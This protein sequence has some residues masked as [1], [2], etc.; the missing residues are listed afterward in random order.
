MQE[1]VISNYKT[2]QYKDVNL[3]K[4]FEPEGHREQEFEFSNSVV[5]SPFTANGGKLFVNFYT[6]LPG[7]SSYPYH[8]HTGMEEVFYIISGTAT[9]ESPK[10]N[11]I[12]SEGDVIVL[13]ANEN[14]AHKFTNHSDLPCVYL[15]VDTSDTREVVF[16]PHSNKVRVMT[17]GFHKSFNIDDEVNFL[18]GEK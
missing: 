14:G 11:I 1:M 18:E 13:P 16:Y 2:A 9:L 5:N 17:G 12:V 15:D 8:Y 6:L 7:K 3:N 10:G 4:I